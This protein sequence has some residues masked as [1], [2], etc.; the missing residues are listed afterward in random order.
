MVFRQHPVF[1]GF[2]TPLITPLYNKIHLQ[3]KQI[4]YA[5]MSKY[6]LLKFQDN[7]KNINSSEIKSKI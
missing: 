6:V 7:Y 1:V 4:I 3:F 5:Y 2:W